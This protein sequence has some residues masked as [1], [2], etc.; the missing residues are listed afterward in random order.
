[1][2]NRLGLFVKLFISLVVIGLLI[3]KINFKELLETIR[4]MSWYSF[5]LFFGAVILFHLIGTINLKILFGG[6]NTKIKF[7][8][9]LKYSA[10]S[11]SLS[12][13]LPGK[14]GEGFL[15]YLLKKK[16]IEYGKS[17]SVLLVD[18]IISLIVISIVSIC[19]F[20][21]FLNSSLALKI[22]IFL[23]TTIILIFTLITSKKIKN[24][25][26]RVIL[27]KHAILF[28]GF[29]TYFMLMLRERKKTLF[30]NLV[31]TVLLLLALSYLLKIVMNYLG[32]DVPLLYVLAI[33]S[34]GMLVA[35]IPISFSG[36]GIREFAVVQLYQTIGV[37]SHIS[38]GVYLLL[39]FFSYLSAGLILLYYTKEIN[40]KATKVEPEDSNQEKA[41]EESKEEKNENTH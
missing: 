5:P 13:F 36:L 23:V 15:I 38:G 6:L 24:F 40:I 28:A 18:K 1:M 31:F 11:R 17:T 16:E 10:I 32:A 21:I 20:F 35:Q 29:S 30:L 4:F 27:R 41:K 2:K 12:S 33:Q 34:I 22:S 19:G 8:E 7:R 37:D 9:L 14:L 39:A 3:Y 25:I 26:K